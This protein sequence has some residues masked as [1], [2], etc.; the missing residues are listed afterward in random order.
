[1]F[2]FYGN[3]L[4]FPFP[5]L[6]F[7]ITFLFLKVFQFIVDIL[8]VHLTLFPKLYSSK[9]VKFILDHFPIRFENYILSAEL[10]SISV[11]AEECN[12]AVESHYCITED[13]FI[14]CLHH[15]CEK[16]NKDDTAVN[17]QKNQIPILLIHGL[18]QD[19]E[20]F[21]CCEQS[22]LAT[23][24]M[25]ANYDVW[26]G[27]NRGNRY[28]HGH[29]KFDYHDKEYWDYCLDDMARFDLPCMM[30][31]IFNVTHSE[32]I[33]LLGF[34]QVKTIYINIYSI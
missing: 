20:S 23:I 26:L 30:N 5:L 18:M 1:M 32:K 17:K 34:S 9:V 11:L 3:V 13:G 15:L 21:L 10:S 6:I 22:S 27:N 28:S 25:K 12:L 29:L 4:P 7:L 16:N 8:A 19:S 14:L 33:V 2:H 31:Y 24:L